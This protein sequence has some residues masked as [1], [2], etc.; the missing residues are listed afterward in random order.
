MAE[1]N[2]KPV[3]TE[4]D[5]TAEVK[6]GENEATAPPKP[7][8]PPTGDPELEPSMDE[9]RLENLKK[10]HMQLNDEV[11]ELKTKLFY[12]EREL[13]GVRQELGITPFNEVKENLNAS[14][15]VMN[16]K[17][18]QV[19]ES[20]RYKKT[21]EA[22]SKWKENMTASDGYKKASTGISTAGTRTS[23]AFKKAGDA[24]KENESIQSAWG[25]MR[26]ATINL[27]ENLSKPN[28]EQQGGRPDREDFVP[29]EPK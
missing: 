27:R 11:N 9:L 13:N 1:A 2:V 6:P 18:Q 17:W 15:R 12:K 29:D 22:F 16:E 21:G 5:T 23:E 26:S 7:T 14:L 3:L 20:E 10:K 25:R 24:I 8:F 19:K 28:V 4:T